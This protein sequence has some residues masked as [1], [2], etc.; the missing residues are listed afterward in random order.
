MNRLVIIGL[1]LAAVLL[2]VSV[3][4]EGQAK[5]AGGKAFVFPFPVEMAEQF[6]A[7]RSSSFLEN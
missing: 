2:W 3:P 5:K 4:P 1:T 7:K 6:L